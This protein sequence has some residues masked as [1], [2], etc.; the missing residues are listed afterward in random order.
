MN[1]S[2]CWRVLAAAIRIWLLDAQRDPQE[3]AD[4]ARFLEVPPERVEAL[5][6]AA[7]RKL[8]AY[9]NTTS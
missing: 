5:A 3:R 4:L 1:T 6:P 2:A 9:H 7:I 8:A